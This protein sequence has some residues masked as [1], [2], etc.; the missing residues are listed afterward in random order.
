MNDKELIEA[1]LN[2]NKQS[3]EKLIVSIQDLVYNL[4]IRFLWNPMDAEDATQEILIKIITNLSKYDGKSQF[5]TWSYRV[6]TNYLLQ[7][8]KQTTFEKTLISFDSFSTEIKSTKEPV[9]YELPDRKILEKEMKTGCT[10]AMLQCLTKDLRIVFILGSVLKIKSNIACEIVGISPENFRKRLQ[11]ARKLI[12][13]FLDFNCGVYNSNNKCRCNKR[14]N[15]ALGNGIIVKNDL[16]FVDTI[17][18]Y[19][20]EMEELNSMTGIYQNHG[21]FSSKV[22]FLNQ[23]NQVISTKKIFKYN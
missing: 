8:K 21:N 1:C 18:T 11:K 4:S 6:A 17:E 5:K 15:I 9:S 16:K 2:G 23:L 3:L 22:D 13:S 14:I 19:N 12:G 10:L 20:E 7:Q